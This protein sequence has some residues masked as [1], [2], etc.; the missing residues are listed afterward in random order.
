MDTWGFREIF[1][2]GRSRSLVYEEVSPGA[3]L[4]PGDPALSFKGRRPW[5]DP[6]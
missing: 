6:G 5:D 1:K 3:P 4:T 2:F